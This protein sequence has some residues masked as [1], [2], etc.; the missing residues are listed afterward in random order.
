MDAESSRPQADCPE[1]NT[2]RSTGCPRKRGLQ[3]GRAPFSPFTGCV[4][5][6]VTSLQVNGNSHTASERN[7]HRCNNNL[8]AQSQL[9][10]VS[11]ILLP[12]TRRARR[13]QGALAPCTP[14]RGR[15]NRRFADIRLTPAACSGTAPGR[16]PASRRSAC[17]LQ[18]A[19]PRQA[20]LNDLEATQTYPFV[21]QKQQQKHTK[22]YQAQIPQPH[23]TTQKAPLLAAGTVRVRPVNRRKEDKVIPPGWRNKANRGMD[24]ESSRPQADCPEVN[25]VRSTGCPRKTGLLRGGPLNTFTGC[26]VTLTTSQEVNGTFT[27]VQGERNFH[28]SPGERKQPHCK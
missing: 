12:L 22:T 7:S 16:L 2:V 18:A 17:V 6:L 28:I 5:T 1:V 4:A 21:S 13:P 14:F 26:E 3:R 19:P 10:A 25:A 27:S 9:R 24:A 15:Q 20:R 23:Q 8:P 11:A